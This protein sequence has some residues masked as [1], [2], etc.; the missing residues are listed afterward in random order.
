M[1]NSRAIETA[2]AANFVSSF[3]ISAKV[4]VLKPLGAI[5][6]SN[7]TLLV[8]PDKSKT[9][10]INN[11][12]AP[13]KTIRTSIGIGRSFGIVIFGVNFNPS[14]SNIAGETILAIIASVSSISACGVIESDL[15]SK[16]AAKAQMGGAIS[17]FLMM[18]FF[19]GVSAP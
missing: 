9:D 13:P 2:D 1:A 12:I 18:K 7:T 4:I 10:T 8:T 11:P 16:P 14:A 15:Q 17:S 19:C 6:A 5:L 3:S